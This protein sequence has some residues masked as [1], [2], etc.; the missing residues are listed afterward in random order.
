MPLIAV[1]AAI[2]YDR[3]WRKARQG[4]GCRVQET[5][6]GAALHEL[7]RSANYQ[8]CDIGAADASQHP[9]GVRRDVAAKASGKNDQGRTPD[10]LAAGFAFAFIVLLLVTELVLTLPGEADSPSYVAQFYTEHRTLII[11]LQILGV[12]DA[13]LLG[14]YAWR[15]RAVDRFVAGAGLLMAF[16]ALAPTMITLVLAVVADPARVETAAEWNML[17]PRG[18]DILFVGIVLF[19]STVAVRLGR[20]NPALGVLALVVAVAC[21]LRLI[22]EA[23]GKT[24][25]ALEAV[26]PLLFVVLI[27]TMAVLSFRGVLR[28]HP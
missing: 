24:R 27:A 25:G 18:D 17:E 10:R 7:T 9:I 21:L 3:P 20:N 4:P 12:V 16:C 13:V 1:R 5:A 14:A 23:A 2:S 11:A 6:P 22:L 15:L 28:A 26:G 19:A 8:Y